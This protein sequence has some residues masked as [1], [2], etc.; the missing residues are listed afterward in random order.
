VTSF[1]ADGFDWCATGPWRDYAP[2]AAACSVV[3]STDAIPGAAVPEGG[4]LGADEPTV[5]IRAEGTL[6]EIIAWWA[7]VPYPLGWTRA[8]SLEPSGELSARYAVTNA[9]PIALPFVWG[10]S[11]PL[12]PD[13]STSVQIP[14]ARARVAHA[15][16]DG[17]PSAG[18]EFAWP[19]L[20][21]GDR[22]LDV[23]HPTQLGA[24]RA[25]VCYVELAQGR[26]LV[27][28]SGRTL[29]VRGTPGGVTHARVLINAGAAG[30]PG[31]ARGW[32]RSREMDSRAVFSVG[33]AAGA[34]DSLSDAIGSWKAARWVEPGDTLLWDIRFRSLTPSVTPR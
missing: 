26:F 32:W 11:I 12:P 5:D 22:T 28:S 3:T 24:G 21:V 25:V 34:P 13:R 8:L 16:G 33:P 17:M 7:P 19:L 27:R 18:S 4:T 9:H 1:A 14:R 10:L 6:Q 2:S 31:R 23:S 30:A 29:E 20:R 15:F